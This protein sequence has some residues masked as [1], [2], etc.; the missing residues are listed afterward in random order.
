MSLRISTGPILKSFW[1]LVLAL[2]LE[3]CVSLKKCLI[4]LCCSF[5]FVQWAQSPLR[6]IS[7]GCY[8]LG[9]MCQTEYMSD[10]SHPPVANVHL[11][12]EGV[13]AGILEDD[14]W[15]SSR[16]LCGT[17]SL[18]CMWVQTVI[19]RMWA[20]KISFPLWF[21]S[22]TKIRKKLEA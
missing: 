10:V 3:G 9:C 14:W 11:L 1:L 21:F 6:T 17:D 22:E 2:F 16:Q 20:I 13:W 5:P 12:P 4:G 19:P 15:C 18:I 7:Q 8:G